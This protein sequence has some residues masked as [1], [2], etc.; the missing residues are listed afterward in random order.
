MPIL[1]LILFK[2]TVALK[3][4]YIGRLD[5]LITLIETLGNIKKCCFLT[6]HVKQL[7]SS[8]AMIFAFIHIREIGMARSDAVEWNGKGISSKCNVVP[9]AIT[10]VV[11]SERFE[12]N[13]LSKS[14]SSFK[15]L[16]EVSTTKYHIIMNI[17]VSTN[18]SENATKMV[19]ASNAVKG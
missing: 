9:F 16:R 11:L 19:T 3:F 17:R 6:I 10:N 1:K 7:V 15:Y 12:N 5:K 18:H 2:Q 4:Q 14:C 13:M 8:T